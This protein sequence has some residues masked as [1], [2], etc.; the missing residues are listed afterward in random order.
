MNSAPIAQQRLLID[1]QSV[2]SRLARLR[3]ERASLPVLSR[4]EATVERLKANKRQ[5]VLADAALV[6]ARAAATRREDEVA[7]VV[8]RAQTLRER[9]HSGSAGARDLGAI[10]SEIDHL[11][12]RQGVLEE[13]QIQAMEELD[14][15]QQEVERLAGQEQEIRAAGRELTAQRDAEFSRLDAQISSAEDQ[16]ADLAGSIDAALLEIYDQVRARTGGLGAVALHGRRIDGG[17]LE[18]SPHELA[19]IAAAPRD[20]IVQ[21]EENDVIV[22]RMEI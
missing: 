20:A 10:Q 22:V 15:A 9:L 11:G 5:A 12:V 8:R 2:D 4:I 21:A 3:H 19:R 16:R 17:S 6:E 14:A 13:A 7:Q 1:L 18:I